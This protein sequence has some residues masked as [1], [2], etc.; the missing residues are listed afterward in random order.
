MAWSP[1][2]L[3]FAVCSADRVVHL[4]DEFGERKDKFSTKPCDSKVFIYFPKIFLKNYTLLILNLL[5][6]F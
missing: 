4:F 5:S 6:Y 3:K 1:N 2:N